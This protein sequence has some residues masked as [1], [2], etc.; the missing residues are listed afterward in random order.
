[1]LLSSCCG[2]GRQAGRR[3]RP[4]LC[5]EGLSS[6]AAQSWS[7]SAGSFRTVCLGPGFL[8]RWCPEGWP[9]ISVWLAWASLQ[10]SGTEQEKFLGWFRALI[11]VI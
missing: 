2:S 1:M 10:H 11:G 6:E 9:D 7:C 4:R 3:G 8:P 5:S